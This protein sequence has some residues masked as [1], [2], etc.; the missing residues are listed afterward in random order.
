MSGLG[1]GSGGEWTFLDIVT[2]VS[3][4]I[5]VQNLEMNATQGDMARI[6]RDLSDKAELLLNEIHGHLEEQDKKLDKIMGVISREDNS[7]TI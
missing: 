6:Q 3:F 4:I 7:G 5:G 2:L 1:S